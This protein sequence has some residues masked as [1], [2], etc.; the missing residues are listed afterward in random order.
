MSKKLGTKVKIPIY[1]RG[2]RITV[3]KDINKGLKQIGFDDLEDDVVE[4]TVIEDPT[5]IIHVFIEPKA[6]INVICHEAFHV[7]KNVLDTAGLTLTE[8]SEEAYAYLIG[9]VAEKIQKEICK[10]KRK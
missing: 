5:G 2:L 8:S 4:G 9:W 10:N 6:N 3:T 1:D 7:T